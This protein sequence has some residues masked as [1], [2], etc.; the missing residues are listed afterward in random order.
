[1]IAAAINF[2]VVSCNQPF[3]QPNTNP[4][5][6]WTIE[7]CTCYKES[8]NLLRTDRFN[9]TR[10][11]TN[12]QHESIK[13]LSNVFM[14]LIYRNTNYWRDAVRLFVFHIGAF[15]VLLRFMSM[16]NEN[17]HRGSWT[18]TR[19]YVAQTA[20]SECAVTGTIACSAIKH[21]AR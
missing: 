10:N 21:S 19:N 17:R 9:W 14:S 1:M 18:M 8:D 20:E 6:S 7:L 2:E 5:C 15:G 12:L 3:R 13:Y 4:Y 16:P 11:L